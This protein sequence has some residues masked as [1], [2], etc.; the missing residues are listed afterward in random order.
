MSARLN[1][2]HSGVLSLKINSCIFSFSGDST[3]LK[4]QIFI[5]K[6]LQNYWSSPLGFLDEV[7]SQIKLFQSK[8]SSTCSVLVL[9]HRFDFVNR[10]LNIHMQH[11]CL[12]T[13]F[14]FQTSKN[15]LRGRKDSGKSRMQALEPLVGMSCGAAGNYWTCLYRVKRLCHCTTGPLFSCDKTKY[16][17]SLKNSIMYN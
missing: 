8:Y 16:N 7:W 5:G 9:V 14:P 4:S 6:V 3:K 10:I 13:Y 2:E 17:S 11:A 15:Q 1:T 12:Y